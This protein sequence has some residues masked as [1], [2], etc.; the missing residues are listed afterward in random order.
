MPSRF[1]AREAGEDAAP[2]RLLAGQRELEVLEDGEEVEHG[3][4]LELAADPELGDL[5][6]RSAPA[7]SVSSA[8]PHRSLRAGG[9]CRSRRP[10]SSSCRP[11]SGPMT[12]SSS[13]GSTCMVRSSSALNPSK[14]TV[15]SRMYSTLPLSTDGLRRSAASRFS[16]QASR[17]PA[18]PAR[19]PGVVRH[20]LHV[21]GRAPH[22]HLRLPLAGSSPASPRGRKSVEQTN[23]APRAYS[24]T[25]GSALVKYVLA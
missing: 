22:G 12:H 5:P 1:A 23:T 4:L 10:S 7:D 15:T 3:R 6:A 24:H 13:P 25:S 2:E 20:G 14:L 19:H 21:V 11:R 18:D 16:R 8:V 9:S 17:L